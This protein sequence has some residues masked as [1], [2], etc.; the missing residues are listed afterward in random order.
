MTLQ[1]ELYG[2]ESPRSPDEVIWGMYDAWEKWRAHSCVE[3]HGQHSWV[4]E[5]ESGD[6]HVSC[7]LC[8]TPY[9]VEYPEEWA[10][11]K[12]P[13]TVTFESECGNL[14]GWHGIDRCDHGWW[15]VLDPVA[16]PSSKF[17]N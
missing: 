16:Q 15:F 12:I 1:W 8:G 17:E 14:G 10:S 13:V 2:E 6:I 4:L 7:D 9:L 3:R 5:I 11:T